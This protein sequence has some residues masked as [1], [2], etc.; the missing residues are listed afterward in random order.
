MDSFR[1]THTKWTEQYDDSQQPVTQLQQLSTQGQ[2]RFTL[3][4]TH[5]PTTADYFEEYPDIILVHP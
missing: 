2:S 5:F 4:P 1:H 3:T